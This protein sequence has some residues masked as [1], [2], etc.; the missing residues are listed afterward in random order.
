LRASPRPKR[1][2]RQPERNARTKGGMG[3]GKK[4]KRKSVRTES[5]EKPQPRQMRGSPSRRKNQ[6]RGAKKGRGPPDNS[7]ILLE[8]KSWITRPRNI[9]GAGQAKPSTAP[10]TA[11]ELLREKGYYCTLHPTHTIKPRG[12]KE[13][14][15]CSKSNV[16]NCPK[17]EQGWGITLEEL[18]P[19]RV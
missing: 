19:P 5:W 1:I 10:K 18:L 6:E 8:E 4:K 17:P 12:G 7:S 16:T 14:V 13:A 11:Q 15:R 3:G 2:S 9:G